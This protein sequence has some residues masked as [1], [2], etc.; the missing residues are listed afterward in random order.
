MK[1]L[2]LYTEL[3]GYT[4]A[5]VKALE[6]Y[7]DE[8]L[9]VRYPVNNEAPFSFDFSDSTVVLDR[10]KLSFEDLNTRCQTFNPDVVYVSGWIDKEYLKVCKDLKLSR[11]V[12]VGFDNQ[13]NGGMKQRLAGTFSQFFVKKYFT[14]AWVPGQPQL[15]FA[16]QLGFKEDRILTG[17]Y[18]A[19]VDLFK[20][21]YEKVKAQKEETL[22]H[23]FL[24]IGRYV[25]WKGVNEMWEAFSNIQDKKGWELICAGTGELY[26]KRP[27][28][29]G[30]KHLGFIQPAEL[31]EVIS[32]TS[33]FILPSKFE[34]WGVAVQEY[35]AAGFPLICSRF[36][37]ASSEFVRE[38]ENG[39]LLNQITIKEIQRVMERAISTSDDELRIMGNK[40]R[41][42]A[43]YA[44]PESWAQE[45][46]NL[47][48]K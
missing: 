1:F 15:K 12:V 39:W 46:I 22:P 48:S 18:A 26:D 37:G 5:C 9:I 4:L 47:A 31:Q 35:A 33:V 29:R 36:V 6:K 25:E 10:S 16:Q 44:T 28:R 23:R 21:Y 43:S 34:P 3:A 41:Q 30:I 17:V 40:S 32:K 20:S 11:P 14:H 7:A 13:W 8:I 45:L 42:L 38:K 2:F 24:Y 27:E 19:D